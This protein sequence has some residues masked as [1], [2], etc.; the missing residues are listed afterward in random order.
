MAG[1]G[2]RWRWNLFV[3]DCAVSFYFLVK[4][5]AWSFNACGDVV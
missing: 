3:N 4:E 2:V 1:G 5:Y